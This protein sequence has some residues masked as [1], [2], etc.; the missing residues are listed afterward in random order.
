MRF[1]TLMTALIVALLAPLTAQAEP[2]KVVATISI[3]ADLTRQVGG[4]LVQVTSIV[5]PDGDAHTYKPT[6]QDAKALAEANLIITNGLGLEGWMGRLIKASGSK[7]T[8][9]VATK[10]ITPRQMVDDGRK[11]T[12]PHSWQSVANA[13]IYVKNISAALSQALPDQAA[14]LQQQTQTYDAQLAELD[15]WV[16]SQLADIPT[17]QR[18]IITSHDAFGYYSGEYDITLLAPQGI[19]TE[20]EPTAGQVAKLI[21]QM[22]AQ[23][24]RRVFFENMASPKVVQRLADEAQA[25]VGEPVFS[26]ALSPADGPAAT[27]IAMI[28]HNTTLFREAMLLN[29]K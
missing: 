25:Q 1:L 11:I 16:K 20:S 6:P 14:A 23:K 17:S 10:G 27:Y 22:K 15:N 12:D 7:A 28:R 18:K 3:L 4:D 8:V 26:D 21:N 19:S 5:G 24:I 2:L 13:R 9:I 29:G